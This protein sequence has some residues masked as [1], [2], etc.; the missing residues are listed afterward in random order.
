M[1]Y[2]PAFGGSLGSPYPPLPPLCTRARAC[3]YTLTSRHR[4]ERRI[5]STLQ[6]FLPFIFPQFKPLPPFIFDILTHASPFTHRHSRPPFFIYFFRE[7]KKR[8]PPL[9]SLF[10]SPSVSICSSLS[11][12]QAAHLFFPRCAPLSFG[13]LVPTQERLRPRL[14]HRYSRGSPGARGKMRQ[15]VVR[16]L[17]PETRDVPLR[18][19]APFIRAGT[20]RVYYT[21]V[22]VQRQVER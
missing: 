15:V 19:A 8:T 18:P 10:L 22:H 4:H 3:A 6:C 7:P 12:K 11:R 5:S 13:L 20:S 21:C 17:S 2:L 16:S 14:S 1:F 9:V